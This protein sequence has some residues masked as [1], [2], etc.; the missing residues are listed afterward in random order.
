[1]SRAYVV[2]GAVIVSDDGQGQVR[3]HPQCPKCGYVVEYSTGSAWVGE[4]IRASVGVFGNCPE[5]G[6]SIDVHINRGC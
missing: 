1:M 3:F 5:C 2:R 6:T 4:G